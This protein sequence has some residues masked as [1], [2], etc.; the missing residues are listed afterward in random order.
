MPLGAREE[1]DEEE[2]PEHEHVPLPPRDLPVPRPGDDDHRLGE[3]D[4][5]E[6]EREHEPFLALAME[7][8]EAEGGD[9]EERDAEGGEDELP[10]VELLLGQ[11]VV[12]RRQLG[13]RDRGPHD[14]DRTEHPEEQGRQAQDAV[15]LSRVQLERR[16]R[17]EQRREHE[18]QR[19]RELEPGVRAEQHARR[20]QRVQAEEGRAGDE[21]ERDEEE[22]PV[23]SPARS[24]RHA[25]PERGGDESGPEHEPEVR[26]VVLPRSV[27]RRA[28][29]EQHQQEQRCDGDGEPGARAHPD[30]SIPDACL[31][32]A[33]R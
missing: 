13:Q 26:R 24:G 27:D 23:A 4:E 31:S 3:Q 16:R 11:R 32:S 20:R 2:R 5:R 30:E 18:S 8:Q 12:E 15:G 10:A 9:S 29:E 25:E 7:P 19:R 17:R 33:S 14:D 1:G 22:P 6:C 21:R 28:R